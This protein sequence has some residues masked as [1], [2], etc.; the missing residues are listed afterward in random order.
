MLN[1][2][3]TVFSAQN[4]QSLS[5]VARFKLTKIRPFADGLCITHLSGRGQM[6][7][8]RANVLVWINRAPVSDTGLVYGGLRTSTPEADIHQMQ[9][10]YVYTAPTI[11]LVRIEQKTTIIKNSYDLLHQTNSTRHWIYSML[12]TVPSTDV[13]WWHWIVVSVSFNFTCFMM[14]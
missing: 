3:H 7:R 4:I 11:K 10:D 6:S 12:A 2:I 14:D 13:E 9:P 8:R 1:R 5:Y